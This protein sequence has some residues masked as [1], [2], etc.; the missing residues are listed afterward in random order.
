MSDA[1][2]LRVRPVASPSSSLPRVQKTEAV[3]NTDVFC[4]LYSC[5]AMEP[6]PATTRV[7]DERCRE[8]LLDTEASQASSGTSAFIFLFF[9]MKNYKR[10][11][12]AA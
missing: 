12:S 6:R 3:V 7:S 4:L 5:S 2:C 8:R 9:R 1:N 10:F 11:G